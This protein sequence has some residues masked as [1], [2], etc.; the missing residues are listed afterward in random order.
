MN[1]CL[2]TS[3]YRGTSASNSLG[4]MELLLVYEDSR[5]PFTATT[6]ELLPAVC[7]EL[8]ILRVSGQPVVR[9]LADDED[10]QAYYLL[11]RWS[12]KWATYVDVIDASDVVSGDKL[13]VIRRSRQSPV[14]MH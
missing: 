13:T 10:A 6:D 14:S 12:S 9:V 11:Q 2:A 1:D 3:L 5:R 8:R 4:E 7:N